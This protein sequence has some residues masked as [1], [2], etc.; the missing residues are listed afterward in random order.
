VTGPSLKEIFYE[1][2]RLQNE[3]PPAQELKAVQNYLAG[4]FVLQNSSRPGIIN[5]LEYVDLHGLPA[6]YLNTY[7]QRVY[8]VTPLDVQRM[9]SKY[10]QDDR[11]TIVVVGDRKVIEEQVKPYG[12]IAP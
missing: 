4:V 2:D 3:P 8:A 9:A 12:T 10:I 6:D 1:I 11:A 5:Q 7:V